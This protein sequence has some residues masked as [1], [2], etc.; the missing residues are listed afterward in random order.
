MAR[1]HALQVVRG[2]RYRLFS[3]CIIV[4]TG[5]KSLSNL[6]TYSQSNLG[7]RSTGTD[8]GLDFRHGAS[9]QSKLCTHSEEA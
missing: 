8:I 9:G 2:Y 4:N 1:R 6:L 7:L 3:I 5:E